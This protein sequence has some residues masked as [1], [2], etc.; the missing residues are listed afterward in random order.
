MNSARLKWLALLAAC[1]VT[2]YALNTYRT[3]SV[4]EYLTSA[5]VYWHADQAVLTLTTAAEVRS[6]SLIAKGL[7]SAGSWTK[8]AANKPDVRVGA[9]HVFILQNGNWVEQ[10][11][12]PMRSPTAFSL[13][14]YNGQFYSWDKRQL[15]SLWNGHILLP[16][17][18][19]RAVELHKAFPNDPNNFLAAAPSGSPNP[20]D[21]VQDVITR[22]E[23][24]GYQSIASLPDGRHLPFLV[25]GKVF[26]LVVQRSHSATAAGEV[27]LT[28][29]VDGKSLP[30]WQP[31]PMPRSVSASEFATYRFALPLFPGR[32][33]SPGRSLSLEIGGSLL[34][35]L[36]IWAVFL[37]PMILTAAPSTTEYVDANPD[38]YPKLD[39][40]RWN[41]YSAELE[42]LGFVR[43]RDVRMSNSLTGGIA[44]VF[45]HPKSNCYASVHQ[46]FAPKAPPLSFGFTSYLGEDWSIGHGIAKPLSGNAITRTK[47]KLSFSCPDMTLEQLYPEHLAR[48]DKIA[49]DLGLAL[50]TPQ[51]FET[52]Q[53]RSNLEAQARRD[54]IRGTNPIAI[55]LKVYW[56]RLRPLSN[57]WLG[58][59]P[60]EMASRTGQRFTPREA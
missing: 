42:A 28:V 38:D 11:L 8:L 39:R 47:H 2:S 22:D 20:Y 54:L 46:V 50:V 27:G 10:K 32:T 7:R 12:S 55:A 5:Q 19:P 58:D 48:R 16:V 60:K 29:N 21:I 25:G 30:L 52:Y 15:V 51:G 33:G 36:L 13:W 35:L 23:W 4:R 43:L 53:E 37:K 56:A 34:T 44:R 24:H 18:Q 57:N 49:N 26:E 3:N 14:P 59:Y 17:P 40:I 45:L 1:V 9:A 6:E 31:Q 41:S